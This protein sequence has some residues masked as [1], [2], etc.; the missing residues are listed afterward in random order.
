M[1]EEDRA[2]RL[3]RRLKVPLVGIRTWRY[4]VGVEQ[5]EINDHNPVPSGLKG[6]LPKILRPG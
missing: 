3:C 4:A 6:L 2:R 5:L 1:G